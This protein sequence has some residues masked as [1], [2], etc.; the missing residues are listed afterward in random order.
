MGTHHQQW[1]S[2]LLGFQVYPPTHSFFPQSSI[3]HL[4]GNTRPRET[5]AHLSHHIPLL[6]CPSRRNRQVEHDKPY[7]YGHHNMGSTFVS[8]FSKGSLDCALHKYGLTLM[9]LMPI[10]AG[11]KL[12]VPLSLH[13]Y[14]LSWIISLSHTHY[15]NHFHPPSQQESP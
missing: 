4:W 12:I 11:Y 2:C 6:L 15:L 13:I 1:S 7:N 14:M 10:P 5:E 9:I 3:S 8:Q